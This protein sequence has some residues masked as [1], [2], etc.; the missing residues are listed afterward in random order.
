[1][2]LFVVIWNY[3]ELNEDNY[4]LLQLYLSFFTVHLK[5]VIKYTN[6]GNVY[7]NYLELNELTRWK[8]KRRSL[9]AR[10]FYGFY[11]FASSYNDHISNMGD[12][13][14]MD[15]INTFLEA[16]RAR[17]QSCSIKIGEKRDSSGSEQ[18]SCI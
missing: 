5:N 12:I 2:S 17:S 13:W 14:S 15:D 8:L 6:L 11:R 9:L 7:K 3:P 16:F 18:K 4:Q 10:W 1:M